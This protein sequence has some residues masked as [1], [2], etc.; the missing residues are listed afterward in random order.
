MAFSVMALGAY[1]IWKGHRKSDGSPPSDRPPAP[2]EVKR[3]ISSLQDQI[4]RAALDEAVAIQLL[5]AVNKLIHT[6]EQNMAALKD[7]TEMSED[8]RGDIRDVARDLRSLATELIR[9]SSR[10]ARHE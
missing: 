5:K 2:H 7:N 4:E 9:N 3:A 8:M 6:I 1:G 10:G